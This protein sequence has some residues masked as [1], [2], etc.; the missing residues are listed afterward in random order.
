MFFKRKLAAAVDTFAFPSGPDFVPAGLTQATPKYKRHAVFAMLSLAGFVVL[1]LALMGWFA[2]TAYLIF[3]SLPEYDKG[4]YFVAIA[5]ASSAFLAL[6]MAKGLVFFKKNT[7]SRDLEIKRAEYPRLF[8]FLDAIADEA[9]APK[10]HRV[11]LSPRVNAAV[12]Y[13]LTLLDLFFTSRKNLEIG[14][15]LVNTLTLTEF[16]AVL[17][18]EFGHFAQ[19]SMAVGRWVYV[20]Q[21]VATE[22][23][24]KRDALDSFL[25][26][27]SRFDFRVAWIGWIL[28]FTVWS[29]RSL[30]DTLLSGVILAQRALS[31]EMEFQADLVSVSLCGSE[32][33]VN[34]LHKLGG[35]DDAMDRAIN[36]A[37]GERANGTPVK[38]VFAIQTRVL[39]HLRSIYDDPHYG[40]APRETDGSREH[41]RVFK[42]AVAAPPRM[43]STHPANS[44]REENAKAL[45]IECA[46]DGRSAW[47]LFPDA[48]ALRE[49]MTSHMFA[50]PA[51]EKLEST[52][53]P[54]APVALAESIERLDQSF[55]SI[56]IDKRYRGA[57]LGRAIARDFK[58]AAD[59]YVELPRGTN[60]KAALAAL[61]PK[62]LG[63]TLEKWRE[64][65]DEKNTFEG[66]RNGYL[67]APGGV[68][69]WRGEEI[70]SRKIP[71]VMKSL[72]AEIDTLKVE[73]NTHDRQVRTLHLAA[74]RSV[75]NGWDAYLAGLTALLH[76]SEHSAADLSDLHGVFQNVFNVVAADGKI[77]DSELKRLIK[78]A[79]ELHAGLKRVH[80]EAAQ[81]ALDER[82]A[83]R[84]A[85]TDVATALGEFRLPPAD[86]SNMGQWLN[87][88]GGWVGGAVNILLAVR[89]A[90]L[91]ELLICEDQVANWLSAGTAAPAAPKPPSIPADYPRLLTGEARPRQTKLR[92]WDR[93]QIADGWLAA[94]ARF[95]VALAIVG[96]VIGVGA[97]LAF[98]I[99]LDGRTT[100]EA[101][102]YQYVPA[103]PDAQPGS[104]YVPTPQF[105]APVSPDAQA[106]PPD[107]PAAVPEAQPAPSEQPAAAPDEQP[108]LGL[109]PA[110]PDDQPASASPEV[111]PPP[112][113]E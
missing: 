79:N 80:D 54:P 106:A 111:Q 68:V 67:Q 74:A 4:A 15:G 58:N 43:W 27:V 5:G 12:F 112:P 6:F 52:E 59:M 41:Y 78:A 19:K 108:A 100:F 90:T 16:K 91:Q 99:S 2:W 49:R 63:D 76:Y 81:V 46:R 29:L 82:T 102:Q 95:L 85:M 45:F 64:L 21:Q 3:A 23:V 37:A 89:S 48:Q 53:P 31:R 50:D 57:Y 1:Y 38:D 65:Q 25:R 11:F 97:A 105:E 66:L 86:D 69:R 8:T 47:E 28:Q 87:A 10:P 30:I 22:I 98:H 24:N 35:V 42:S 110:S 109:R 104:P 96:G 36:F 107:E 94:T 103:G 13:D 72:D 9:R 17:A 44:D 7:A 61:Y 60:L 93:F 18:H 40:A 101:P 56:T 51:P 32:A 77:S 55:S 33:I 62:T 83:K 71:K 70:A 88:I 73:V 113:Q 39:E 20:A 14:L 84:A 34:A 75:G 26:G 92:W